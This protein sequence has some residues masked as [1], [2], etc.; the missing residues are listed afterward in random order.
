MQYDVF[1]SYARKDY[2]DQKTK[3]I[4]PGNIVSRIKQLLDDNELTYWFDEAGIY[5][6]DQFAGVIADSIE[7][8][9]VFLYISTSASND[10]KWTINEIATAKHLDKK[11]IP[12]RYDESK[13]NKS[14]LMYLAPL[15]HIEYPKN[16]DKAFGQLIASI[17]TYKH[18]LE[19]A[20]QESRLAAE[21]AKQREQEKLEKQ[22][23]ELEKQLR[24]QEINK[25]LETLYTEIQKKQQEKASINIV[26]DGLEKQRTNLENELAFLTGKESGY[27]PIEEVVM[28]SGWKATLSSIWKTTKRCM[29]HLYLFLFAFIAA[30]AV[31]F[32]IILS[33]P[34]IRYDTPE[35]MY[36][37]GNTYSKKGNLKKTIR[38]YNKAAENGHAEAQCSMGFY[39]IQ[40]I[41]V[42]RDTIRATEWYRKAA[43]QG[44]AEAQYYLGYF[45]LRGVGTIPDTIQAVEWYHKAAEQGHAYAQYEMGNI[46]E[47]GYG[48]Q[49]SESTAI[50]WYRKVAKLRSLD[51]AKKALERLHALADGEIDGHEY[52][53]LGLSV[54]WATC[55]VEA[56]SPSSY[57][58]KVS[59]SEAHIWNDGWRKPTSDEMKELIEKCCWEWTTQNNQTG[60][61]VEGPNGNRIFLPV[62][63]SNCD[64]W[65]S[66]YSFDS[67][68][69]TLYLSSTSRGIS[70]SYSYSRRLCRLVIE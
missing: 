13:Y 27:S 29:H 3:E 45:Y 57:G 64:Y 28:V 30:F 43:E 5:S 63:G 54:K 2:E 23:Q 34:S 65:S 70:Y 16:K 55:N 40:G 42:E 20:E 10:S 61:S 25:Q 67:H 32:G 7:Q 50:D 60:Y 35:K 47:N 48:V 21:L 26:L 59:W 15:D 68:Y 36:Q 17:K 41:G 9:T 53:D 24:I 31:L 39:Y 33:L 19:R 69:K 44:H 62:D 22:K 58:N 14:I 6:G 46:C 12:F 11:I 49:R 8:S 18:T 56:S 51:E 37:K 1:I 38:W 66:T 4:I 52:V